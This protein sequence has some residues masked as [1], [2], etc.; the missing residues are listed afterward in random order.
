MPIVDAR[1]PAWLKGAVVY[2]IFARSFADSDGDGT[3]DLD[4]I[5]AHLDYLASLGVNAIWLTPIHPTSSDHGYDVEDYDHVA[6]DLGGDAAFDRFQRAAHARGLRILLDGVFNHSSSKH[7]WFVSARES[8]ASPL[9]ERYIWSDAEPAG[10]ARPWG[11]PV[12]YPTKTGF[13]YALFSERMPD[14]NFRSE[15]TQAEVVR[16]ANGWLARGVDGWRL[17]AARHLVEDGP[18]KLTDRPET[19]S[20]W[21]RLRRETAAKFPESVLIGETWTDVDTELPYAG[22]GDELHAAFDF[23]LQNALAYGI[24]SAN[25]LAITK[26]IGDLA[27][28]PGFLAPFLGNHDQTRF[29]SRVG[30]AEAAALGPEL[31]LALPGPLFVYYGDELGQQDGAQQGDAAKRCPMAWTGAPGGGF[32]GGKPYR[33]LPKGFEKANVAAESADPASLLNLWRRL[34]AIRKARPALEAAPLAVVNV[35]APAVAYARGTG[36]DALVVVANLSADA[37]AHVALAWPGAAA[38]GALVDLAHPD[39]AA[40]RR[41]GGRVELDLGPR[42]AAWLARR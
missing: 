8:R 30:S 13:Y 23:D 1:A 3:G 19:H 6:K 27:K 12:W 15:A 20:F 28:A 39:R 11:G 32:S 41:A 7:P 24:Q 14:L 26:A 5:T 2:Q 35:A 40:A 22:D 16:I 37:P 34:L 18:G 9:R 38:D 42:D 31:L 4:G 33:D 10:W 29:A 17:D 25:A 36:E 21:K